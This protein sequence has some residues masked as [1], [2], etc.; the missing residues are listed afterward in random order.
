MTTV[1]E[2]CE[3]GNMKILCGDE[4]MQ[5]S[6]TG[7]YCGDLLSWVMSR[8]QSGDAWLTVMGNVN[9]VGV[10]ALADTACIILTENAAF[11]ENALLRAKQNSITVLQTEKNTYETAVLISSLING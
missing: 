7:C 6:V 2:I 3:K 1:K 4:G 10:A 5:R 9:A 8:A 11:D